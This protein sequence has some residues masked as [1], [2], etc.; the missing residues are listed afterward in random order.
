MTTAVY[1][2]VSTSSQNTAGQRAEIE[3]WLK[4]HNITDAQFFIDKASGNNLKRPQF[5]ALQKAIFLGEVKT[6]VVWKL[7][8]LSRNLRDGINFLADWCDKGIRVVSVT[9]Q[10]DFTQAMGKLLASVFL[11]VAEMEQ[12]VRKE[13][14]AVGIKEAKKAGVYKG[15]SP[16]ACKA[17]PVKALELRAKGLTVAQV[18]VSMGISHRTAHRYLSSHPSQR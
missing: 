6:I 1:I 11:A 9:Q 16:G 5:N 7:D 3:R 8:R 10:L 15:R 2:R 18:A 4:G 17:K 14:Q 12:E 13:R